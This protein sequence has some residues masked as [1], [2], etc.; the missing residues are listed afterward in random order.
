MDLI[1]HNG[2]IFSMRHESDVFSAIAIKD[3]RIHTIGHEEV[4]DLKTDK[5]QVI[6]LEGRDVFPG[7]NDSHIH[8]LGLGASLSQ[9]DLSGAK[10]K[11]DVVKITK[12]Y[13]ETHQIKKNDWVVGRGWNQDNFDIKEIVTADDLDQIS[14]GHYLFLRRA[15]GH[16][17][18]CNSHLLETFGFSKDKTL[19]DGGEYENGVFKEN[20]LE[21]V[22]GKMPIPT[23]DDLKLWIKT[24]AHYLNSLGIT[25]VQSDDLCVF[26]ESLIPDVLE[27]LIELDV[28]NELSVRV[29]EQSLFRNIDILKHQVE[30][31]YKQNKGSNFFKFGP[32][33]ILGDGSLGGR[34]AWL[35]KPY[36]DAPDETGIH[37]Y[38]QDELNEYVY[39]AHK[40]KIASAIHCIGDKMLDSALEAI[41]YAQEK[42]PNHQLRH[43]IVHCQI[44]SKDQLQRM[45]ALNVMAYVQPIF[46][47]YDAHIVYDR[48]GKLADTSYNWKTM[49][50]LGLRMSFG[51]DA[52][53]DSAD[54]IKGIHCAVTRKGL[55]G[56][57]QAG[58]LKDQA[59]SVYD[60]IY[61]YT[62]ESAYASFEENKKGMLLPGFL[63][64][65]VILDGNIFENILKSKV[66]MT[67]LGG[68]IKYK[69]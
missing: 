20:A 19:I 13:L 68:Q 4:I 35:N 14:Q 67:I 64:D 17:A 61:N 34:T 15:C 28:E 5:T 11:A 42:K 10:S 2:R 21:L 1:L 33:K 60:A 29:Y 22:T 63:A 53:V 66:H 18:T 41:E 6:D 45:K 31:G 59:I 8:L 46:L 32:L 27:S 7:F 69:A 50:D 54:P 65:L 24:G 40:N 62:A 44:T 52:P 43:G 26:S 47:D 23:K 30:S 39:F 56:T 16:V 58:Y 3:G 55:D 48:V 36:A 38:E 25:S 12:E 37:M 51:S 49:I 9:V 57:P